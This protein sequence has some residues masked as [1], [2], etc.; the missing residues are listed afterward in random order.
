[1]K[2]IEALRIRS[3]GED[4]LTFP[5]RSFEDSEGRQEMESA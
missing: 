2:G 3:R 4:I 1:M 5:L